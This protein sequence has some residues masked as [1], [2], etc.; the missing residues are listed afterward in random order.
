M[1]EMSLQRRPA[2]E[3]SNEKNITN[4]NRAGQYVM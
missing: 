1:I 4:M 3:K 2:C